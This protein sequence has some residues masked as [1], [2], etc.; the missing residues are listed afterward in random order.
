VRRSV[1]R[2]LTTHLGSLLGTLF[3]I[4]VL[5]AGVAPARADTVKIGVVAA[6]SGPYSVWGEQYKHAIDLYLA[7][8]GGKVGSH[9]MEII[10]RDNGGNNPQRTRQVTQELI[11]RDNVQYLAGL[12]FTPNALAVT[13]LLEKAK[14]PFVLFNSATAVVSR[15]SP[16]FVRTSYTQ[17]ETGMAVARWT[18]EQGGAKR[19]V[20]VA[21]DY[22][23]GQDAADAYRKGFTDGG[24]TIVGDI[25]VPL[26]TT[27]FSSYLQLIRDAAPDCT[28]VFMPIGPMQIG[29]VRAYID[30]G[31]EK[32]GIKL[33]G[34]SETREQDLPAIGDG[35]IGVI[36]STHY[37]PYLDN[38]LNKAF[39]AGLIGKFGQDALPDIAG[40][41]AYDGMRLLARMIE[42]T[43]GKRDSEKAMASVKGYKWD[44]PRG[45]VWI[46]PVTRDIVNNVYIRK[47]EKVDGRLINKEF[48]VYHD[49]KDP[50]KE[51]NPE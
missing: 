27:D 40:V 38:P 37:G 6:F 28:L 34:T 10:Y 9:T 1:D 18:A 11:V 22:A 26:D 30:R 2:I 12:E 25:R 24:G 21:A 32:D 5:I 19:A 29:F 50:W 45:M 23:S 41:A 20:I 15:K 33:V 16:W 8:T 43:D 4:S 14:I 35:A 51:L 36:T 13:D 42:A 46:D 3:A 44:S 7:E 17:W 49:V 47:V 31:L 39:V 48:F